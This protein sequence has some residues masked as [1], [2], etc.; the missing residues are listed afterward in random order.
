DPARRKRLWRRH[1]RH[2]GAR[3]ETAEHK[4]GRLLMETNWRFDPPANKPNPFEL[5]G[6]ATNASNEDIVERGRELMESAETQEQKLLYRWAM[7]QL[8]THP[9]TRLGYEMLEVPDAEYDDEAWSR[10]AQQYR[11][12]PIDLAAMARDSAPPVADDFNVPRLIG[13]LLDGL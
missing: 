11:R 6:L 10:F 7:E 13:L 8:I 12:P 3:E 4:A 2:R 1:D 5:L 9:L